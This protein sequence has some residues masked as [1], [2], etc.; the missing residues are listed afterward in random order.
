MDQGFDNLLAVQGLDEADIDAIGIS[1]PG[2]RK[3]LVRVCVCMRV[4]VR[5]LVLV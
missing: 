1:L 5:T 3:T 2:H 4:R